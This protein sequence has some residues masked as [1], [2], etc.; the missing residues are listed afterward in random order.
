VNLFV[1]TVDD[2]LG[3][4]GMQPSMS[5]CDVVNQKLEV[6][7]QQIVQYVAE[8]DDL[9]INSQILSQ[10]SNSTEIEQIEM[11]LRHNLNYCDECLMKMYRSIVLS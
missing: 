10:I 6:V 8:H 9:E 4:L 1:S 7:K 5:P 11:I 2:I 3:G